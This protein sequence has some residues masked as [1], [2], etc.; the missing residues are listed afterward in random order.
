MTIPCKQ[1]TIIEHAGIENN[2]CFA[3]AQGRSVVSFSVL[4]TRNVC[5]ILVLRLSVVKRYKTVRKKSRTRSQWNTR[6][7]FVILDRSTVPS[8]EN[9]TSAC[10]FKVDGPVQVEKSRAYSHTTLGPLSDFMPGVSNRHTDTTIV[11]HQVPV[12]I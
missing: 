5:C 12:N 8:W 1:Y 6:S 3:H 4:W 10:S 7:V 9:K 2:F 11:S